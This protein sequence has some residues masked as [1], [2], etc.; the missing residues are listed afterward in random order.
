MKFL[1]FS[2]WVEGRGGERKGR[3]GK[4]RKYLETTIVKKMKTDAPIGKDAG[5]N[6][7][8]AKHIFPRR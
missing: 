2:G 6:S 3:R 5:G 7:L 1:F 8:E 4:Q